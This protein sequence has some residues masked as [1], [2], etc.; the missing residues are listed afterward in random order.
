MTTILFHEIIFYFLFVWPLLFLFSLL[1]APLHLR[2]SRKAILFLFLTGPIGTLYCLWKP[3]IY[4]HEKHTVAGNAPLKTS[5]L[6][7]L[8]G[9]TLAVLFLTGAIIFFHKGWTKNY[10]TF[11][12]WHSYIGYF[13]FVV[14]VLYMYRHIRR[15]APRKV[16]I[17]TLW[18]LLLL[19]FIIFMLNEIN[20]YYL[21]SAPLI[22]LIA[23][24][25][26]AVTR[27]LT[28][29]V[30]EERLL[31]GMGL[32]FITAMA[33][34]TG[35]YLAEPVNT[36]L[37]NNMALYI[38]FIH[39]SIAVL[40]IPLA[41]SFFY[42]HRAVA[43][44]QWFQRARRYSIPGY[45]ALFLMFYTYA[46]QKWSGDK[47]EWRPIKTT[48]STEA[49]L[50]P[51]KDA[52]SF[53]PQNYERALDD[54]TVCDNS[55][56][57]ASL[58][59]QWKYSTHRFSGSNLF[60]QKVVEKFANDV[61]RESTR[62]CQNCHDPVGALQADKKKYS[63]PERWKDNHGITCKVCHSISHVNFPKGNGSYTIRREIPYP[64]DMSLA[65]W[66]DEW[67]G[68]IRWDLRLH[69]KN[70]SNPP[71]YQS[72]EYC[73][74]CHRLVLPSAKGKDIVIHDIYKSWQ[75]SDYAKQGIKCRSCHMDALMRDERGIY[76]PD[77]RF[78][79]FN[80]SLSYMVADPRIP[81]KELKNF[82]VFTEKWIKGDVFMR[83]GVKQ[84]PIL[85]MKVTVEKMKSKKLHFVVKTKNIRVGHQ[86]PAGALDLNEI[87]LEIKITDKN[88]RVVYHSGFLNP[89]RTLDSRAHKLGGKM[90]DKNGKPILFHNVWETQKIL[91][92]REILPGKSVLDTYKISVPR[93]TVYPLTITAQWNY[94][95]A[96]QDFVNWVFSGKGKQVTFPITTIVSLT[97][98]IY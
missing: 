29:S 21:F 59:Q 22:F 4:P 57:H 76:F 65:N 55:Q 79:G 77:H 18:I 8:L 35:I 14:F 1:V 34:Y 43:H 68:Y 70:Y 28:D 36:M 24:T 66:K 6:T 90:V 13:S 97:M 72:P 12:K 60:F 52:A 54:Y 44:P 50:T 5:P 38:L 23:V 88:N 63:S 17:L 45:F 84:S 25:S 26:Y 75:E 48:Y 83:S 16:A 86:F 98:N 62:F 7:F 31:A 67:R 73:M 3:F 27:G 20:A 32:F 96:R 89:D 82:E 47:V 61:G 56:C 49:T 42:V 10:Y 9:L 30:E 11:I 74:A 71:L 95:R 2:K 87:W 94:R 78:P 37:T 80:Q 91:N 92:V 46:H 58:V 93:D 33:Y 53:I 64:V 69:F 39:G 41:M 51:V 19:F 81:Q 15:Y 85:G 40:L